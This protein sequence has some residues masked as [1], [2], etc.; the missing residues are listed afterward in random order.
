[1]NLLKPLIVVV[2][3]PL[4]IAAVFVAQAVMDW[5]MPVLT[6]MAFL[7]VLVAL[8]TWAAKLAPGSR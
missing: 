1:M 4:L 6:G 8:I 2:F 3:M 5:V 7:V